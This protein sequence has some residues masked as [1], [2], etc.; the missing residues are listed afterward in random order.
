MS[1]ATFRGLFLVRPNLVFLN[2]GSFGACPKP[3]FADYQRWQREL[4]RQPVEFLGRRFPALMRAA[5]ETL[6]AYVGTEAD[7]VVYVPN[8]TTAL[9]V[10]ARSLSLG[11]GDEVVGTDHE[12]GALDR[13]WTFVCERAGARYVRAAV[14]VPVRS[15]AAVIETIWSAVTPRTRVLFCSHVTA[16]TALIF[17][18]RELIRRARARGILTVVDG[19][20]APG[21][22]PLR[23]DALGAD[24]YAG[25]C[26][27]WM[28]A[29]KG[30][31]FLYAR[32]E[33]QPLLRPLVV[34]WGWRSD[35]PSGSP[36]IDEQ[37]WQ[38]TRDVAAYL[39]VP[40]AIAFLRRHRW[41]AVRAR[42][43]T[44]AQALRRRLLRTA[45][46]RALSV[47]SPRWYAQMV[48]VSLPVP[49]TEAPAFQRTLYERYRIEVPVLAWNG[50]TLL[51]ASVQA[52]NTPADTAALV[53]A[54]G[55][56]VR[57]G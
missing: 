13:T 57:T 44:L 54:V 43:H 51:R 4:E 38:G 52:Y 2:H 49:H 35:Q 30:A 32:P 28:C 46:A 11:P 25:N 23:L 15:A 31:G 53:D 29:P 24:F 1:D 50:Q 7:N 21:Q 48:S 36:F 20:H 18:V 47:D 19:A 26:H 34:S 27:K 12:Y 39:A 55:T 16:P 9:N 22:I 40:A 41:E 17:P 33:V 45:G 37:Q 10:V 5:R 56:L 42:C 14:A 8:A 3:V 6:A